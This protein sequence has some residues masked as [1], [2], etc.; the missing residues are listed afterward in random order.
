LY[1]ISGLF[2]LTVL[3][4]SPDLLVIEIGDVV[5]PPFDLA[6]RGEVART[7]SVPDVTG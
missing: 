5:N 4:K 2:A 7:W 3:L 6:E 1:L